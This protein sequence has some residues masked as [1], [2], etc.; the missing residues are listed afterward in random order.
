MTID[1]SITA[2]GN[3]KVAGNS[4]YSW[5]GNNKVAGN[6]NY[7]WIGNQWVPPPGVRM[8]SPLETSEL[9]RKYNVLFI[10]DSNSRQDWGTSVGIIL[11]DGDGDVTPASLQK[12]INAGKYDRRNCML[13]TR[14]YGHT[15]DSVFVN[16]T[17]NTTKG[18][19]R[20]HGATNTSTILA[21]PNTTSTKEEA[22]KGG[23]KKLD[24]TGGWVCFDGN[25]SGTKVEKL[26]KMYDVLVV[27]TGIW[28]VER[29]WECRKPNVTL[30]ERLVDTLSML[31]RISSPHLQVIWKTLGGTAW[32]TTKSQMK[33]AVETINAITRK[34]FMDQQQ[35]DDDD[36]PLLNMHLMDWGKQ[37]LPRTYGGKR[38]PGDLKP[39]WGTEARTLT[40]QMITQI[41]SEL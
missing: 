18:H 5:I 41:L 17:A 2:A 20:D 24:H 27:A 11:G 36:G 25:L 33:E 1:G 29:P 3:N 38:I 13:E 23:T 9:W 40:I 34:W 39:H 8:Y 32:G 6:S 26:S 22:K 4:N 14:H 28:E 7:S 16:N 19:C 30:E 37:I 21:S 31:K 12:H 15:S 10:G 35:H